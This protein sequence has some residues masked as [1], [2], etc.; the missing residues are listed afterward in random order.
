MG[1]I[2]CMVG[3]YFMHQRFANLSLVKVI[4]FW[5]NIKMNVFSLKSSI[6]HVSY[7]GELGI[8]GQGSV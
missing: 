6:L 7:A 3:C 8:L 2:G 5:N 4:R 1:G